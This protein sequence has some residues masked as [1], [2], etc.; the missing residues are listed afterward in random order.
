MNKLPTERVA[1][2]GVID[3]DAYAAS[4]YTTT[5]VDCSKFRRLAALIAV[6]DFVSTGV[7]SAKL[8]K[9]TDASGTSAEDIT[10]AA[11]TNLTQAGSDDNKQAWINFDCQ[12]L[13]GSEKRFVRLSVTLTT[14]GAD[15]AA[16]LF[17]F[18]AFTNPASDNDASTVDEI[19]SV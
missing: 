11:I 9:C 7:L 4:T 13:E 10:N 12:G 5:A 14:A 6:G 15:M 17:G 2:V 16:F 18:D 1:L 8:Q 3:A 19:V